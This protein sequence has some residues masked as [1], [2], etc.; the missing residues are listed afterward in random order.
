MNY[1]QGSNRLQMTV[2]SLEDQIEADNAVGF[3]DAFVEKDGLVRSQRLILQKP[4]AKTRLNLK[5]LT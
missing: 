2:S 3:I 4:N 5:Q 1:V